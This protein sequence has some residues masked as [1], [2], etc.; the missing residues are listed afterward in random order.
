MANGLTPLARL[1]AVLLV[2]V[3]CSSD[4]GS[5]ANGA[6]APTQADAGEA[7]ASA[8]SA[9]RGSSATSGGTQASAGGNASGGGPSSASSAD[10]PSAGGEKGGPPPAVDGRSVYTL[11]CHGDS[12]DCNLAT[13]PCFGISSPMPDV[14]AGWACANRCTSDA[15]CSNEPSGAEAQA[16]CVPFTASGHCLLVCQNEGHSFTCPEGM[17]CYTPAKPPIGYCLWQ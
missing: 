8:G 2:C 9:G 4:E 3:G 11:E 14:A 7:G 6:G 12:K 16:G 15:D 1:C 13:V 5:D 17:S 10:Q